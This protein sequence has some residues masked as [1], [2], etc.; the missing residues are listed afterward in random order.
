M[1]VPAGT[2]V[3]TYCCVP[4]LLRR[5]GAPRLR[6]SLASGAVHEV[7]GS[8]L[9]ERLSREIFRRTGRVKVIEAWT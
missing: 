7:E 5:S 4:V 2:A 8:E 6:L 3:F 9:D 1:T